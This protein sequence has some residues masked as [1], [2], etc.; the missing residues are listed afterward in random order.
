MLDNYQKLEEIG[1]G[2]LSFIFFLIYQNELI[3]VQCVDFAPFLTWEYIQIFAFFC[4]RKFWPCQQ[5]A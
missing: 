3:L 5:S 1:K 4:F 2:K